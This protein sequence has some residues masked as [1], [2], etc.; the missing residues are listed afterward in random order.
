[1][2][3]EG[4]RSDVHGY[5]SDAI[6]VTWDRKRCIHSAECVRGLPAVFVP[7]ERPWVRPSVRR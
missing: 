7:G 6:E 3:D 4:K 1:M 5:R 2:S